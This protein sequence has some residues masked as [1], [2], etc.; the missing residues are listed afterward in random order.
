MTID[1]WHERQERAKVDKYKSICGRLGWKF[2]PF[3]MDVFGGFAPQSLTLV[4]TFVKAQAGQ[5]E[6]WKRRM[7]EASIWQELSL[8]L[9]RDVGRQLVWTLYSATEPSAAQNPT[10][11]E[12]Y[13]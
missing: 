2:I 1:G 13:S 9:M 7:Q 10:S 8:K 12:P 4:N 11:H 5:V 6:G 3:V